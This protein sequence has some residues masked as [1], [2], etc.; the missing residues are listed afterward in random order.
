MGGLKKATLTDVAR[1]AGVS[2]TTASYVLNGRSTQMRISADTERRVMAAMEGLNYRPNL[3]ARSLRRSS[4][5]TIGL[6]SDRVATGSFGNDLLG[7]ASAAARELDHLLVIGE[8]MGDPVLEE[9]LIMDMLDRQVDGIVYATAAASLVEVPEPLRAGRTVLLN[10][11]DPSADLPAVLPDDVG[12]GRAAVLHLLESG[13]REPVHVVGEDPAPYS[14]AGVDRLRGIREG[15]VGS[16][17]E[18]AGVVSCRWDVASAHDALEAWLGA[19]GRP[20]TLICLNDRI[21]MGAYQALRE[22]GICVPEDVAV[23]SFDGS[24]LA[25]WL[26]PRLTS[27]AL[28]FKEMGRRAVETLMRP[29]WQEAGVVRL[30]MVLQ[31]GASVA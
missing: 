17:A 28:P 13:L 1:H 22:R 19:G 21:A 14:T 25:A 2:V 18:V 3:T 8:S 10:C 16:G 23:I 12:G 31:S 27:L 7:G 30:P 5:Q 26:R 15:F 20:G 9:L 6:I 24:D 29:D 4:T 11:A